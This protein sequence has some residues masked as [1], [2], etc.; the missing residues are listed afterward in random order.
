MVRCRVCQ[1]IATQCLQ[2]IASTLSCRYRIVFSG[3]SNG[4]VSSSSSAISA[5]HTIEYIFIIFA[6]MAGL[7]VLICLCAVCEK[8]G[9]G[10][11][12]APVQSIC[13][14]LCGTCCDCYRCISNCCSSL[15]RF[16]WMNSCSK[17]KDCCKSR[18]SV[19]SAP[20]QQQTPPPAPP[21][22]IVLV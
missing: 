5:D 20:H 12:L 4:S 15:A 2:K 21:P 7:F 9:G 14:A 16:V 18:D 13:S 17:I 19:A 8:E 10:C 1:G 6:A 3:G 22:V 11:C